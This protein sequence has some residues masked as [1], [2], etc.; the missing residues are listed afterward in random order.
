M[1]VKRDWSSDAYA[2][3]CAK[4]MDEMGIRIVGITVLRYLTNDVLWSVWGQ[5]DNIDYEELDRR[6]DSMDAGRGED[7]REP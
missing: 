4:A 7:D 2:F 1:I 6:T 5:A 3:Q